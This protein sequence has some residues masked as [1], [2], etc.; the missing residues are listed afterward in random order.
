MASY[1]VPD[2][3][4]PRDK[5]IEWAILEF[6]I[7]ESEVYRQANIMRDWEYRRPIKDFNRAF[8]RWLRKAEEWDQLRKPRKVR[9][10]EEVTDE[11]REVDKE[12]WAKEMQ[13]RF[14]ITPFPNVKNA[15][16]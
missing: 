1:F 16:R 15:R 12:K 11:Q 5:D 7:E 9:K 10:V 14:N 6:G 13:E 2:D 4:E 3:W 8:R